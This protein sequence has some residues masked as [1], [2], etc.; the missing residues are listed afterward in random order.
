MKFKT[1]AG[2]A[3]LVALLVFLAP[4]VIKLEKIALLAVVLIGIGLAAYEFYESIRKE[5]E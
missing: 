3:G 1:F 4:P 2:L 5:D